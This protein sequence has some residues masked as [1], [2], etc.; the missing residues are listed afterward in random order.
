MCLHV[1]HYSL[2]MFKLIPIYFNFVAHLLMLRTLLHWVYFCSCIA[3][4]PA[5]LVFLVCLVFSVMYGLFVI[6]LPLVM[7]VIMA[8][9]GTLFVV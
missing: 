4:L 3:L 8:V 7:L 6:P 5:I 1:S 2:C 9:W